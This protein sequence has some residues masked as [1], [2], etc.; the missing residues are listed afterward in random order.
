MALT[1]FSKYAR[2]CVEMTVILTNR[3]FHLLSAFFV[4]VLPTALPSAGWPW[5]QAAMSALS[6][7]YFASELPDTI[8][9]VR[10][11]EPKLF[12]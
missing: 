2:M 10:V 3:T 4:A 5:V 9:L 6:I 12:L 1:G 11:R 8:G 7:F